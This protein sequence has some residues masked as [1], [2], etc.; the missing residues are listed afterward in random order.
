MRRALGVPTVGTAFVPIALALTLVVAGCA[1]TEP[2]PDAGAESPTPHGYV[3]GAE[4]T[5]DTQYRLVVADTTDARVSVVDLLTGESSSV[6]DAPG[7]TDLVRDGRY[8]YAVSATTTTVVDSGGWTVDHADHVHYY[9][10]APRSPGTID[11]GGRL[12]GVHADATHTALTYDRSVVILDREEQDRGRIV[13]LDR[14]PR[15][16]AGAA[17]VPLAGSLL[18]PTDDGIEIRESDGARAQTVDCRSPSAST[19]ARR[20]A[21]FACADA[22]VVISARGRVTTIGLPPGTGPVERLAHRP[23]ANGVVATGPGRAVLVDLTARTATPL[24]TDVPATAA[25]AGET[26]PIVATAAGGVEV[27]RTATSPATR[28][29]LPGVTDV[30]TVQ[31]DTAR[32]YVNDPASNRV[33]EIDHRDDGRIARVITTPGRASLMV[34]TGR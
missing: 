30:G 16:G 7:T 17:T 28:T 25:T 12:L 2:A 5:A 9:R 26:G 1:S 6:A 13:V 23:G 27:R 14:L 34:E 8:A 29:P 32:T 19:V 20:G 33:F 22:V 3:E 21:V 10:A 4:E 24:P 11:R 15:T 31:I 18:T